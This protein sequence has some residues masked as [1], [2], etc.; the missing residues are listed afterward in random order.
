[1][2]P[3]QVISF[4]H[5]TL[6][7]KTAQGNT[8]VLATIC[9]FSNWTIYKAVSDKTA[10]T[11]AMVIIVEV[12]ANYGLP[13]VIISDKAPGYRSFLFSTI[14][15]IL[16]VKHRFTA[17]Q[18]KRSNGAAKRSIR[19]LNNGLRNCSTDKIDDTQIELILPIIQISLRASV[20]PETGLSSFKILYARKMPL[21]SYVSTE[22][23]VK[24]FRSTN[25]RNYV[26]WL[27]KALNSI[28]DGIRRNKIE[29]KLTMKENYDRRYK[30]KEAD[31]RV[32]D[33]VLLRDN[34]IETNSNRL[35]TRKPYFNDKFTI[36]EVIEHSGISP[37]YKIMNQRTGK[38]VK[39]LV[40]FNRIKRF[41]MPMQTLNHVH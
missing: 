20:N 8:H 4:D 22:N 35:L 23:S 26:K 19:A 27:R 11:T 13:S 28:N 16:G 29:S 34:R 17:T 41:V 40:N 18:S 31:Y 15:K 30:T 9:H 32:G 3:F 14:N 39:N 21:P 36:T 7:R 5:K 12:V 6:S 33:T 38:M 2:F 10:Q 1:M 37:A 24:N 25:S